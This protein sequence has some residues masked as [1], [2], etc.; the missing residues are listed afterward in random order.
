MSCVTD[1]VPLVRSGRRSLADSASWLPLGCGD[2][3]ADYMDW[4]YFRQFRLSG[5]A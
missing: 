1:S 4:K 3:G 2:P 5:A